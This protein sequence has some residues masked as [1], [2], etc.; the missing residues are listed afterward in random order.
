MRPHCI[1]SSDVSSV[2]SNESI[3]ILEAFYGL[4]DWKVLIELIDPNRIYEAL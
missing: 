1:A 3:G 2:T 4:I